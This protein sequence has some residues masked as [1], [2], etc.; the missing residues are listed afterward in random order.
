[1]CVFVYHHISS[2]MPEPMPKLSVKQLPSS[3]TRHP[4]HTSLHLKQSIGPY[5]T[6]RVSRYLWAAFQLSSVVTSDRFCQLSRMAQELT[7]LMAVSERSLNS[8][9]H[10]SPS[11]WRHRFYWICQTSHVNRWLRSSFVCR[12]RYQ[13]DTIVDNLEELKTQVYPNLTANSIRPEW[14]AERA[15]ISPLNTN[16]N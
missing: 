9:Q 3:C 7:S 4:W 8:E 1:M 5:R 14:L 13:P 10:E 11:E 16:I 6:S 2:E 15:I 12:V